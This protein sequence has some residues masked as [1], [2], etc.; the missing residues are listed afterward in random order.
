MP[1]SSILSD[2]FNKFNFQ[3]IGKSKEHVV[4]ICFVDYLH[5]TKI[6][7][8][9]LNMFLFQVFKVNIPQICDSIC[10]G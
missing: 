2:K 3:K 8:N 4:C 6:S 5:T 7:N 1:I 10:K 9:S